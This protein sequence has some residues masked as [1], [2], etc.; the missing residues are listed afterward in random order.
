MVH[1]TLSWGRAL[2]VV[3]MLISGRVLQVLNP[4]Q[5]VNT[6]QMQTSTF[7][8]VQTAPSWVASLNQA[9]TNAIAAATMD[10]GQAPVVRIDFKRCDTCAGT[11]G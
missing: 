7:D 6:Q 11:V 10:D 5:D 8:F 9:K 2:P 3:A 4:T 1:G